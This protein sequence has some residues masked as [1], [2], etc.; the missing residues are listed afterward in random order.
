MTFSSQGQGVPRASHMDY[1]FT[2]IGVGNP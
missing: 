2:D 1:M